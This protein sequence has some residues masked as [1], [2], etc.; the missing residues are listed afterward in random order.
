MYQDRSCKTCEYAW[1]YYSRSAFYKE[2]ENESREKASL[3]VTG[4]LL[5]FLW[6]II[7]IYA[8][9]VVFMY[10]PKLVFQKLR[11]WELPVFQ[12]KT[13]LCF[14]A[15]SYLRGRVNYTFGHF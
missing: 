5:F 12:R 15:G 10:V 7:K 6:K 1:K 11:Q 3:F 8:Y 2:K 4:E 14:Y 13:A 9:V